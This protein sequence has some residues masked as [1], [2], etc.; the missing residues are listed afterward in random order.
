MEMGASCY[1]VIE[2]DRRKYRI[3]RHYDGYPEGVVSDIYMLRNAL[4]DPEYFLAN[5]IFYAKLSF[6]IQDLTK[7]T[8]LRS[9]DAG[10]GVSSATPELVVEYE[11]VMPL[12][13]PVAIAPEE[14]TLIIHVPSIMG[15]EIKRGDVIFK[16]TLGEAYE[17]Y[18]KDFPDGCHI[19]KE[20]VEGDIAKIFAKIPVEALVNALDK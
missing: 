6:L 3:Y 11:Y 2:R 18:G 8:G 13:N 17:K 20:L 15:H 4:G 12:K 10:Y 5:L 14:Q 1:I 16:G 7:R 19:N 9:W